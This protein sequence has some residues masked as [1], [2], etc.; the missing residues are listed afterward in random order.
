MQN[1]TPAPLLSDAGTVGVDPF[2]IKTLYGS[3]SSKKA[4][5]WISNWT[6]SLRTISVAGLSD[7]QDPQ[8]V[9]RGGGEIT[10]GNG[11]AV[12]YPQNPAPRLYINKKESGSGF[13][14]VEFTVYAKWEGSGY[15]QSYAGFTLMARTNHFLYES[16]G[17]NAAAYYTRIWKSDGRVSFQ[18]EY[19][20]GASTVYSSSRLTN[21]FSQFPKS[22]WIG[23]KYVVYTIP[24]TTS[25]QLEIYVDL[26]DGMDGGAWQLAHSFLD[27][28]GVMPA[29][30]VVPSQCPI[31]SGDTVLGSRYSCILRSDGGEIHWKKAS[32]R[33]ILVPGMTSAPTPR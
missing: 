31:Q 20:H 27:S 12:F 32:I 21:L 26:T 13:E 7:P 18:K 30:A 2:G 16:D 9:M 6:G 24:G 15:E 28:K 8:T 17:C 4:S 29:L 5:D 1:R 23:M 33:H 3:D 22:Q 25:V 10:F 19:F 14:N 11:E